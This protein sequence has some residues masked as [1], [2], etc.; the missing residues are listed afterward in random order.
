MKEIQE[1]EL[2]EYLQK[3]KSA[4]IDEIAAALYVSPSTVRRRLKALQTK[5]QL[6]LLDRIFQEF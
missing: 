5:G 4:K 1:R 6:H 2:L 3:N